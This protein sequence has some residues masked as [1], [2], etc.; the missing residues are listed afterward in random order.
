[1]KRVLVICLIL[2]LSFSMMGCSDDPE[3][4][5]VAIDDIEIEQGE[6]YEDKLVE[7]AVATMDDGSKEAVE[8]NWGDKDIDTD[9]AGEYDL[10][11]NVEDYEHT[12]T[13][14]LTIKEVDDPEPEPEIES[15]DV[16]DIE[17]EQGESYEDELVEKADATFNDGNIETVTID[18]DDRDIDTSK[19]DEHKL[20]GDVEG[21]DYTVEI[22]LT[23]K[24][25]DDP[26]FE[27]GIG[28]ETAPEA[29]TD[30]TVENTDEGIRVSWEDEQ[31]KIE[32]YYIYRS[33]SR[34][35]EKEILNPNYDLID[36][37]EYI[38]EDATEGEEYYYWV[39]GYG[40]RVDGEGIL[41][42]SKTDEAAQI[43]K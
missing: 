23:I 24:E 2:I 12:V 21:Y 32:G 35:G 27:I 18:W 30:L 37:T 29:P 16:D 36:E 6:D 41:A 25:V 20:T 7:Q 9:E 38:D 1:M 15:V 22:T 42:G 34:D 8:I 19:P 40:Q 3:I 13:I 4:S 31:E 14:T 43:T 11:A 39:R 10:T 28:W 17:I 5:S 33:T 26:G